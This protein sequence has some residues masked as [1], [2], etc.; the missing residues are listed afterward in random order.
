MII[1]EELVLDAMS[2]QELMEYIV[3]KF[4]A[5]EVYNDAYCYSNNGCFPWEMR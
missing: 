4:G 5:D 1:T 2:Y 3:E